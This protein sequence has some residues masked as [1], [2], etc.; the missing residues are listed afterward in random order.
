MLTTMSERE[1]RTF[2]VQLRG[3]RGVRKITGYAALFN[4]E[5]QDLGGF[6]EV[7]RPGAFRRTIEEGAD[8]RALWNHDDSFVL[9]RTKSG[10]LRLW[11][12]DRGLRI[13]IDPPDAQWAKDA[14]VSIERGDVDQMSFAFSV[15]PGGD[16]WSQRG[17]KQLRELLDVNLFDVS[18]VTYPAYTKTTVSARSRSIA[19]R[20]PVTE[21]MRLRQTLAEKLI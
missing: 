3:G 8:V 7:I 11:E 17:G 15:A 16:R 1:T 20:V 21:A 13:E 19:S 4:E 10:T 2:K 14:V 18:P 5:S 12:D 6:I 9:G